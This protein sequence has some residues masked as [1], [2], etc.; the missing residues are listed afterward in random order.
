MTNQS[1]INKSLFEALMRAE[2]PTIQTVRGKYTFGI[3]KS[4]QN[5]KRLSFSKSL[6]EDLDVSD[7]IY[8]KLSVEDRKLVIGK[9]LPFPKPTKLELKGV[10][11]KISYNA[12]FVELLTSLFDLDFS[13][14][15]SM[16]MYD[17]VL[18][19]IDGVP[20]AVISFP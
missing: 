15:S 7:T 13:D 8:A 10:G 16:T 14:K 20:V 12:G 2:S 19:S 9:E 1:P 6:V 18:D 5:G 17:I 11:K 3:V 4:G